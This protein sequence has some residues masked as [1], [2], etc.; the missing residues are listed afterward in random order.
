MNH[1]NS[2]FTARQ[3]IVIRGVSNACTRYGFGAKNPRNG[4]AKWGRILVKCQRDRLKKQVVADFQLDPM[5][6]ETSKNCRISWCFFAL[7]LVATSGCSGI[8]ASKSISPLDFLLPG[9]HIRNDPPAPVIPEG[10]NAV[11]I[12]RAD[13]RVPSAL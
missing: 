11:M 1:P 5:K 13:C 2:D 10:T 9:L 6:A 4:L 3:Q 7:A 8:Q 12:A